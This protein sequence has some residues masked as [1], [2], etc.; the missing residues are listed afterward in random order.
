MVRPVIEGKGFFDLWIKFTYFFD[1]GA[2][3]CFPSVHAV[4]GA[5]MI[6][7]S[8][9]TNKFPKWLQISSFIAGVG[10]IISTVLIKQH[11]FIDMV[12]GVIFMAIAYLIVLLIDKKLNSKKA[13]D[14]Q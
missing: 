8:F 11:Y 9:K 13:T 2:L 7:A 6:I 5:F 3:N 14:S 1:P 10:C 4:M 12:A